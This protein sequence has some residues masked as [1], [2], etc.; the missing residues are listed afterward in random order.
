[1]FRAAANDWQKLAGNLSRPCLDAW[2]ARDLDGLKVALGA[3]PLAVAIEI[4]GFPD[5]P[6]DRADSEQVSLHYAVK[7]LLLQSSGRCSKMPN[8]KDYDGGRVVRTAE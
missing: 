6:P 1:M 7:T 2:R 4:V 3:S 8:E 5:L